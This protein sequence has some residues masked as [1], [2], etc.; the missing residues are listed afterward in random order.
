MMD[1]GHWT[2]I[3]VSLVW[4]DEAVKQHSMLLNGFNNVVKI[5][6]NKS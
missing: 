3:S 6:Q 1:C 2:W 4:V 5:Q